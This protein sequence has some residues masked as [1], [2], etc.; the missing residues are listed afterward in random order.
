MSV[1]SG[2]VTVSRVNVTPGLVILTDNLRADL[3]SA[4]DALSRRTKVKIAQAEPEF[5]SVEY[6]HAV[7]LYAR[8]NFNTE[9]DPVDL[10]NA[11]CDFSV[12]PANRPNKET[13]ARLYL[14]TRS[15]DRLSAVGLLRLRQHA[16][17]I[18][19][20]LWSR[21][22]LLLPITFSLNT[23]VPRSEQ[24]VISP[25]LVRLCLSF[26]TDGSTSSAVFRMQQHVPGGSPV[27]DG[28]RQKI[29]L[30]RRLWI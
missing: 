26:Q 23:S 5:R 1:S 22:K 27:L 10:V 21:G 30:C 29:F 28:A 16:K 13:L 11:L 9:C 14:G 15:E 24:L 25:E 18:L 6:L 4:L 7:A 3:Q 2:S 20:T 19:Y 17:Y 12:A 8:P